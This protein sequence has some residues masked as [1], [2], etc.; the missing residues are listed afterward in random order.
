MSLFPFLVLFL[1]LAA[2]PP[3]TCV[4]LPLF[5]INHAAFWKALVEFQLFQ[6]FRSESLSLLV[7]SVNAFGWPPPWT[8]GVLPLI[9]GGLP[10]IAL[11]LLVPCTAAAFAAAAG[12]P[13]TGAAT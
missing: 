7:S 2:T 9:G 12:T 11:A 6:P 3:P 13:K 8:Y 4:T 1:Y 5:L 10:A